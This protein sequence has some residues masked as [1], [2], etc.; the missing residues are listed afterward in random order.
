MVPLCT[1]SDNVYSCTKFCENISGL[2]GYCAD[3]IFIV[4]FEKGIIP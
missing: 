4:K 1:S 3:T 2:G